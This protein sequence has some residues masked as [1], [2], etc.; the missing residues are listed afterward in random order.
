MTEADI[1]AALGD[2]IRKHV[3]WKVRLFKAASTGRLDVSPAMIGN[4]QGCAFGRW[5]DDPSM[6]PQIRA[7]KPWQVVYRLHKEVHQIAGDVAAL[8]AENQTDQALDM[9]HGLY[10]QK[11]DK[12]VS[13][14]ALWR[15]E[16][17][18]GAVHAPAS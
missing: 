6:T 18:L 8:I 5:L 15:S 9:M 14:L 3:E 2:A 17:R 7:G 16:L 4:C 10:K 13:A 12:L 11:S 1:D